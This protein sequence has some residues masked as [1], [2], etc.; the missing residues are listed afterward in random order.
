MNRYQDCVLIPPGKYKNHQFDSDKSFVCLGN[1]NLR[2]CKINNKLF[3]VGNLIAERSILH[4]L[5]VDGI[6]CLK[7][8]YCNKEIHCTDSF[9][10][11]NSALHKVSSLSSGF[12]KNVS[13]E[14]IKTSIKSKVLGTNQIKELI[15]H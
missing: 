13:G 2:N 1:L 14:I 3:V 5:D 6:L 9:V 15:L 11:I 4:F 10:I 7:K 8:S 12:I